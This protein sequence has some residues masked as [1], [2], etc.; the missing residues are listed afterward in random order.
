[1]GIKGRTG[2]EK[3]LI[4]SNATKAIEYLN[5]P[6]IIVPQG[7]PLTIPESI[8]IATICDKFRKKPLV[9]LSKLLNSLKIRKYLPFTLFNKK[10]DINEIKKKAAPIQQQL[11]K[12]SGRFHLAQRMTEASINQFV[13]DHN[14]YDHLAHQGKKFL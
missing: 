1:M 7:A 2:I 10:Q 14:L 13:I 8:V 3:A 11:I 6:L 9:K 12:Y 5:Y 4:G